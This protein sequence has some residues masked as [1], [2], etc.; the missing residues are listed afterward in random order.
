MRETYSNFEGRR[1]QIACHGNRKIPFDNRHSSWTK[2]FNKKPDRPVKTILKH[3][4]YDRV[5][6]RNKAINPNPKLQLRNFPSSAWGNMHDCSA[7]VLVLPL[8]SGPT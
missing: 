3:T 7:V 6:L 1:D 8:K 4:Y 2:R 5:R